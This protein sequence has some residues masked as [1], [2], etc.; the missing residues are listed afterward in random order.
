MIECLITGCT[1]KHG[2]HLLMCKTHWFKVSEPTRSRVWR[3]YRNAGIMSKEYREARAQAISEA[4]D[5]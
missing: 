2:E 1:T 5:A 3:A 4:T